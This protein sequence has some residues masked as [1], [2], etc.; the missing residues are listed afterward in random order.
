MMVQRPEESLIVKFTT[1]QSGEG[2]RGVS[3]VKYIELKL[4]KGYLVLWF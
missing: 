2:L 3:E 1:G 4:A